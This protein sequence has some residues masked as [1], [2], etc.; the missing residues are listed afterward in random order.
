MKRLLFICTIPRTG[1]SLL[2]ADMRSTKVMGNPR[3][4]FNLNGRY[5]RNAE[6]WDLEFGDLEGHIAKIKQ[7]TSTDNG[8]VGIKIF[9]RHLSLMAREGLLAGD[10]GRLRA[11]ATRFGDPDPVIVTLFR[12]QRLRQAISFTKAKQTGKWGVLRTA[13]AEPKYDRKQI[14]A[15]IVELVQRE[16]RWERELEAS[17]YEAHLRLEYEDL[18]PR[19]D[20]VLLR[21]AELLELDDPDAVVAGRDAGEVRLERQ[22]DALTEE[23]HDRFIKW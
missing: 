18:V 15:D 9:E 11:L 2:V 22:A 3:E 4:Y 1:S 8:V 14:A 6:K 20:E 10:P 12:R 21:L 17:G 13:K 7:R 5:K 16:A 23:W 19:R